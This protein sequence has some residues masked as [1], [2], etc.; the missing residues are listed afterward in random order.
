MEAKYMEVISQKNL[1]KLVAMGFE[2]TYKSNGF[3]R[4]VNGKYNFRLTLFKP[5]PKDED[6]G[7]CMSIEDID[8]I[9]LKSGKARNVI[10]NVT[11]WIENVILKN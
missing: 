10:S 8:G 7:I 2:I 6:Q 3:I 9:E 5:D 4:L 11:R 1:D